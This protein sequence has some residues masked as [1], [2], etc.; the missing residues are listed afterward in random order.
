MSTLERITELA[1]LQLRQ[2]A[3][4][5]AAEVELAEAKMALRRTSEEDL[6]ELMRELGIE[7]ITLENGARVSLKEEVH[8]GIKVENRDRAAQWLKDNG[9]AGVLKTELT[10]PFERGASDKAHEAADQIEALIGIP[11]G[12]NE[13]VHPSTLKS[14]VKEQLEAGRS[15]PDSI[16]VT[17]Y[18]VSKIK[19]KKA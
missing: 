16:D 6:P 19:L 15:F 11:P 12:F 5:A 8:C 2:E 4:V 9:F 17:P 1:Q 10:I 18:T 7:D 13:T 14:F 3:E